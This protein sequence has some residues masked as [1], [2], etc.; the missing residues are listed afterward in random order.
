MHQIEEFVDE[1]QNSWCIH[2]GEWLARLEAN[3][4]HVPSKS[5]LL[6]PYPANL[7][8]VKT[9]RSCNDGFSLDEE[10]LVAFL[11]SVIVGSTEPKRQAH[12]AAKRILT[13]NKKLKQQI[14]RAKSEYKTANGK[15]GLV[16]KPEQERIIRIVLKNARGH[17][18]FEFGEPVLRTPKHVRIA[19]LHILTAE[20]RS[21][22]DNV[23]LGHYWPEVGS[24]MLTRAVTGKDLSNGWI[25]VQEGVYRYAV[26]QTRGMLVR[27]VLF[28]YLATEVNWNE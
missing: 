8:V 3:C 7:P 18:F 15:T 14:Q 4:D 28:E 13:R 25:I 17:A 6:K 12:P 9:C 21:Q 27:S 2:C 10:Y 19:P 1:R 22:V 26:A 11:G 23:D 5:F 20:Q 16:W 24:R